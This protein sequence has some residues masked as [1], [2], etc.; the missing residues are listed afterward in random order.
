MFFVLDEKIKEQ[1]ARVELSEVLGEGQ[2]RKLLRDWGLRLLDFFLIL[3]VRERDLKG[4]M[5]VTR[6]GK[7][8]GCK[9][10]SDKRRER[11]EERGVA[12]LKMSM[13]CFFFFAKPAN[14]E[15]FLGLFSGTCSP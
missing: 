7:K 8:D 9:N 14:E 10:D 4:A 2:K 11:K 13:A 6:E 1:R 12:A 15:L 5:S 3:Q